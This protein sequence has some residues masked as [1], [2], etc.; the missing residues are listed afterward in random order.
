ML[1]STFI[2]TAVCLCRQTSRFSFSTLR[3]GTHCARNAQ[4]VT[5]YGT[6]DYHPII[7]PPSSVLTDVA[8]SKSREIGSPEAERTREYVARTR[9]GDDVGVRGG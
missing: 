9:E 5:A 8:A 1:L 2:E 7:A 6:V 3:Y 4:P